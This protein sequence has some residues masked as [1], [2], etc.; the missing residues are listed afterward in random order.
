MATPS[1]K[2]AWTGPVH[3][4]TELRAPSAVTELVWKETRPGEGEKTLGQNTQPHLEKAQL[5]SLVTKSWQ[6]TSLKSLPADRQGGF[7]AAATKEHE[8]EADQAIGKNFCLCQE[9]QPKRMLSLSARL[10]SSAGFDDDEQRFT[11]ETL[12]Q[13]QDTQ[14]PWAIPAISSLKTAGRGPSSPRA[15]SNF[16]ERCSEWLIGGPEGLPW[17]LRVGTPD[18]KL[19]AAPAPKHCWKDGLAFSLR[20][21][22]V[23]HNDKLCIQK[24]GMCTGSSIAPVLVVL[25][26]RLQSALQN[27]AVTKAFRYADNSL[28]VFG[29]HGDLP[30]QETEILEAY[31]TVLMTSNLTSEMPKEGKLRFLD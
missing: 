3:A 4:R 1:G 21:T 13:C 25:N 14:C 26:R 7:T 5:V 31:L 24:K 11:P 8:A 9:K 6:D 17:K 12:V 29:V 19:N 28:V 22:F 16:L 20:S 10:T 27:S 23:A 18:S 30:R 15:T 2:S